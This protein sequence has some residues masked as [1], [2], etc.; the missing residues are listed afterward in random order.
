MKERE[1]IYYRGG[2]PIREGRLHSIPCTAAA[3]SLARL[4]GKSELQEGPYKPQT[5]RRSFERPHC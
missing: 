2:A 3:K 5:L 4:H 1:R